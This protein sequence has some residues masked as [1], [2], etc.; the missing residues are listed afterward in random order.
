MLKCKECDRNVE[1]D[2]A[3]NWKHVDKGDGRRH[4]YNY[5]EASPLWLPLRELQE[6]YAKAAAETSTASLDVARYE[7]KEQEA[8]ERYGKAKAQRDVLKR[9]IAEHPES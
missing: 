7:K 2:E 3:G 1:K 8:R 9:L 4:A 6:T 5:H